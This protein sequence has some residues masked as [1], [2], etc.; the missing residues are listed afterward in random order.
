MLD[1]QGEILEGPRAH[2]KQRPNW[3]G[4]VLSPTPSDPNKVVPGLFAAGEAACAS[5]HGANR[6]GA[7]SLLDIVVYG[8]ACAN[9]IAEVAKPGAAQPE[10]PANAGAATLD[11][12][13]RD[14]KIRTCDPM[15]PRHVRYQAALCPEPMLHITY[16]RGNYNAKGWVL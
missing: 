4:E 9:R 12:L 13:D 1:Q 15:P 10:L 16:N 2:P 5:V 3:R 6:L 14:S 7:N 11:N 8:R